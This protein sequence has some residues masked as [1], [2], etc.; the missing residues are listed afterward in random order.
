MWFRLEFRLKSRL[1]MLGDGVD[2]LKALENS[3]INHL[4][5]DTNSANSLNHENAIFNGPSK[6]KVK[7]WKTTF[8]YQI[9]KRSKSVIPKTKKSNK[10][11]QIHNWWDRALLPYLFP[12]CS[13]LSKLKPEQIALIT[14]SFFEYNQYN[15]GRKHE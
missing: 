10:K 3:I 12:A 13:G 11:L 9:T 15:F 5:T 2:Q 8:R 6:L 14:L 7:I 1:K 4:K